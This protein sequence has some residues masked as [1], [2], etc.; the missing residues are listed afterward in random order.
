MASRRLT[1]SGKGTSQ[2]PLT[3]ALAASPPHNAVPQ[4]PSR[5]DN[6][7]TRLKGGIGTFG[8]DALKIDPRHHRETA[9]TGE[10][11][12]IARA[13]SCPLSEFSIRTA[14]NI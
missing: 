7:I 3:R 6:P 12:V 13:S 9:T 10:A 2:S 4:R 11:P 1:L 5:S 8:N 14:S